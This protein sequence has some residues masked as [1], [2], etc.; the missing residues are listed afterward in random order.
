VYDPRAGKR[1]DECVIVTTLRSEST[2]DV[3]PDP[4]HRRERLRGR[5]A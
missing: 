5:R 3:V 1:S 2:D 4:L